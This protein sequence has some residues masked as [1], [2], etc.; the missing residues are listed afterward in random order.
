MQIHDFDKF[1]SIFELQTLIKKVVAV[2]SYIFLV[3]LRLAD[4]KL[5]TQF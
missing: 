3:T 4:E 1:L 2:Y 5:C